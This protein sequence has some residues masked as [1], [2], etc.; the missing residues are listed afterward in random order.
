MNVQ[1]IQNLTKMKRTKLRQPTKKILKIKPV[2]LTG[3]RFRF[4][5]W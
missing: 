1:L 2:P 3:K 4:T 5:F